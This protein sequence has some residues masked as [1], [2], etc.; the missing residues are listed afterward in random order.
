MNLSRSIAAAVVLAGLLIVS[1]TAQT[2]S[3]GQGDGTTTTAIT[4]PAGSLRKT[5]NGWRGRMLIGAPVFNDSG[6]QIATI[7]DLL[8]TDDGMV[9]RVVLSVRSRQL[10]AIPFSQFRLV[11]SQSIGRRLGRRGRRFTGI[12]T[13]DLGLFGVMLPGASRDSL[14]SMETFRFVPSP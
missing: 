2:P 7:N 4:V 5:Q 13:A 9:D 12:A 1:A 10:V 6:Q 3:P 14:A 8:I 11:P